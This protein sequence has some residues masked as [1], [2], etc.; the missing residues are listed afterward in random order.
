MIPIRGGGEA[1]APDEVKIVCFNFWWK[2][3]LIGGISS[4]SLVIITYSAPT[5][6]SV[7]PRGQKF[8][9]GQQKFYLRPSGVILTMMIILLPPLKIQYAPDKKKSWIRL[10]QKWFKVIKKNIYFFF[11][12]IPRRHYLSYHTKGNW[13][14][15]RNE[16]V[17][18]VKK[19]TW[20]PSHLFAEFVKSLLADFVD[21]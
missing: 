15:S 3:A 14:L 12:F 2:K 17:H 8:V 13:F 19:L 9:L 20:I 18:H 10:C 11:G 4:L 16:V 5:L 1:Y 21:N 6:L 7:M